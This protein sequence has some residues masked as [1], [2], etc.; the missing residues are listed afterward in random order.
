MEKKTSVN[1]KQIMEQFNISRVTLL[2]FEKEGLP[3]QQINGGDKEYYIEQVAKLL[4]SMREEIDSM[5]IGEVYDNIEIY[6]RFKCGNI[7]GMR[8]S[9]KQIH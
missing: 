2:A 3:F 6:R 4:K 7:G 1:Q 8:R 9:I 5:V